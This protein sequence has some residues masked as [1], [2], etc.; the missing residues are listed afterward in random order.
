MVLFP[1]LMLAGEDAC[2]WCRIGGGDTGGVLVYWE[3]YC[4][5]MV[6]IL[7]HCMLL[8]LRRLCSVELLS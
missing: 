4:G 8:C 3:V 7:L 2:D 1:A 6:Q 5:R